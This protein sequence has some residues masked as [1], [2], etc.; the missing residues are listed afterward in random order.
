MFVR[1]LKEKFNLKKCKD[2]I[3]K[4]KLKE[5]REQN[6]GIPVCYDDWIA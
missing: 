1:T 5:Q 6:G 4:E 3:E 2:G